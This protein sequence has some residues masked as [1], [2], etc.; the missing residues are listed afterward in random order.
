MDKIMFKLLFS[1]LSLFSLSQAN[2]FT[3]T[4]KNGKVLQSKK[5]HHTENAFLNQKATEYSLQAIYDELHRAE[6]LAHMAEAA[7]Q[8]AERITQ[9][10]EAAR[11]AGK[12]YRISQVDRQELLEN[13]T[14]IYSG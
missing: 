10:Q 13:G 6:N 11:K 12:T 7:R 1:F 14:R 9:E 5:I 2:L 3:I 4:D 8:R